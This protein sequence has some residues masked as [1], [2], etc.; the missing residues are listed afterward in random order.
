[1]AG[2]YGGVTLNDEQYGNA[3]TIARVGYSMGATPRD[4]QVGLMAAM[5]ESSLRNLNYGDRDSRGL[6]Q[7]RPSQGWGT[8]KQVT[9]PVYA[10]TQFFKHLLGVGGRNNMSLS[11]EAQAVQRSAYPNAYAR[12]QSMG[13]ALVQVLPHAGGLDLSGVMTDTG[14]IGPGGAA[15][16]DGGGGG[17][18]I[19]GD[20][21]SGVAEAIKSIAG[22]A[23]G[24]AASAAS[25]GKL[26]EQGTKLFLPSSMVRIASGFFGAT[27]VFIGIAMLGKEVRSG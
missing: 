17:G 16:S 23:T 13:G 8:V 19:F 5:Q 14:R 1:M 6:F 3:A 10:S 4:V 26:A 2:V 24:M 27:F 21:T 15:G 11:A 25:V 20:L 12:W 22:A 18:G 9:D 7:Q